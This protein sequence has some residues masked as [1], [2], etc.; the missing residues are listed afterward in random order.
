MKNTRVL[1]G[2]MNSISDST[3][4]RETVIM[5]LRIWKKVQSIM[6]MQY[7]QK[8][9]ECLVRIRRIFIRTDRLQENLQ[10]AA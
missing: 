3:Q 10:Q 5:N 1:N 7:G 9:L 2:C 6:K 4:I 8:I